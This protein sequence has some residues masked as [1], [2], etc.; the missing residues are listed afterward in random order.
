MPRPP[1]ALLGGAWQP[2]EASRA[3]VV[4]SMCLNLTHI[5]TPGVLQE[6][7][8]NELRQRMGG[9]EGQIRQQLE[10]ITS[11]K[12]GGGGLAAWPVPAGSP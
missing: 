4:R 8:M 9:M 3:N 5:G 11:L 12:V 1:G 6:L 7:H 10:P 2:A